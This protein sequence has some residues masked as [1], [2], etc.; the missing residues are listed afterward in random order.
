M[1][2]LSLDDACARAVLGQDRGIQLL[3]NI[4]KKT[5]GGFVWFMIMIA[6]LC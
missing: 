2:F 1:G 5:G 4:A 6:L 3:Q